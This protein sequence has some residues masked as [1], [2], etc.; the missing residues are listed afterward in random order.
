MFNDEG[1]GSVTP[2]K[3]CPAGWESLNVNSAAC[4]QCPVG[5]AKS[6]LS[7]E[8][9]SVCAISHYT[10]DVGS[11][12]CL[13]VVEVC[14][15]GE[16]GAYGYLLSTK[17][18]LYKYSSGSNVFNTLLQYQS[19]KM[20]IFAHEEET[21]ARGCKPCSTGMYAEK[22]GD[23]SGLC[24]YCPR[25]FYQ[26]WEKESDPQHDVRNYCTKCYAGYYN[27]NYGMMWCLPAPYDTYTSEKE[28]YEYIE[29]SNSDYKVRCTGPDGAS[30]NDGCK[31]LTPSPDTLSYEF[32]GGRV[33][34][35]CAGDFEPN[36]P[37]NGCGESGSGISH[38][39]MK[40][41]VS[42]TARWVP[43]K[44]CCLH[45]GMYWWHAIDGP[46]IKKAKCYDET[47]T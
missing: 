13:P 6:S 16:V 30:P 3:N 25:G 44:Y 26:S 2:C 32:G 23:N 36:N 43:H 17:Y 14:D 47:W 22:Q 9:C 20:Q 11:T 42:I 12:V 24:I 33:D 15:T 31:R 41:F 7:D 10:E 8:R 19:K 21:I 39:C 45:A 38:Q 1:I 46:H 18:N 29:R 34:R 5:K 28:Q 35:R 37:Q 27:P 4:K 40:Q